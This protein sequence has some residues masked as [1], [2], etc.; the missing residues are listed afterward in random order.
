MDNLI[1]LFGLVVAIVAALA[2]I[3]VW[4]PRKAWVKVS[5][6]ATAMLI[7][8]VAYAAFADLLSK[9]KPVGLEWARRHVPEATVVAATMREEEGIY[10]WLRID[11]VAEP[12]SYVLPWNRRLAEELQEA[13]REA[14]TNRNGLRLRMPFEP[15]WDDRERRFYAPPQPMPPPKDHDAGGPQVYKHP[16]VD[17]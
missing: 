5:A 3:A 2:G 15:T 11:G 7:L 16:S 4:A 17:A 10:L 9:P 6:V 8:A 13:M 1:G 14:E 12:R